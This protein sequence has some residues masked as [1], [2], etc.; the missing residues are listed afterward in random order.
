MTNE[1]TFYDVLLRLCSERGYGRQ[2]T[3]QQ[4]N[5]LRTTGWE[6]KP[7]EAITDVKLAEKQN[8]IAVRFAREFLSPYR[9]YQAGKLLERL[10]KFHFPDRRKPTLREAVTLPETFG[11]LLALYCKIKGVAERSAYNY[12]IRLRRTNWWD[13][14]LANVSEELLRAKFEEIQ[15]CSEKGEIWIYQA[16]K[17]LMC[18]VDFGISA[19]LLN[20]EP[21]HVHKAHRIVSPDTQARRSPMPR[22]KR[23]E[24]KE[25]ITFGEL[26]R[27]YLDYHAKEHCVTWKQIENSSKFY[28]KHWEDKIA[29][30]ISRADVQQLHT[31]IGQKHGMLYGVK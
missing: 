30:N 3:T 20:L 16:R 13:F 1:V 17:M 6:G 12:S 4:I 23:T 24:L 10:I 28:L 19:G 9:A 25:G 29:G 18:L 14:K 7:V 2:A 15:V 11:E 8:E 26:Y 27:T 22:I 31:D 5:L 21:R